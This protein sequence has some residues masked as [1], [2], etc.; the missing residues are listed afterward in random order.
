MGSHWTQKIWQRTRGAS[1]VS[2]LSL[3]EAVDQQ[4]E[5][6]DHTSTT[7]GSNKTLLSILILNCKNHIYPPI[8]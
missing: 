4:T 6:T 5:V 7:S 8:I 2:T 3:A 1:H